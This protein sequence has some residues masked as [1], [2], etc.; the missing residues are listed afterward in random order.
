[1]PLNGRLTDQ[2]LQG[3]DIEYVDCGCQ[4]PLVERA[5]APRIAVFKSQGTHRETMGFEL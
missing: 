5:G 1:M 4:R 2:A 3:H